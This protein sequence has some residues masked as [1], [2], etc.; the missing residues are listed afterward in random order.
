MRQDLELRVLFLICA[1]Y[2]LILVAFCIQIVNMSRRNNFI[3]YI[4]SMSNTVDHIK[5]TGNNK[6]KQINKVSNSILAD[7][8]YVCTGTWYSSATVCI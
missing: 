8:N 6:L 7:I 3:E 2:L 5:E 4:N 1:I